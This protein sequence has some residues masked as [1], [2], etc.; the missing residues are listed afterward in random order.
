M[1]KVQHGHRNTGMPNKV[2]RSATFSGK[3]GPVPQ[4]HTFS[5]MSKRKDK[6]H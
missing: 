5:G 3:K 4:N 2:P 6:G 1:K